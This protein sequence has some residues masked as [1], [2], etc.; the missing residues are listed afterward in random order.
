MITRGCLVRAKNRVSYRRPVVFLTLSEP[1]VGDR[2][3]VQG[4]T[5][6]DAL[7]RSGK[8]RTFYVEDLE[9]ISGV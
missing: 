2:F 1:Y 7:T 5:V 6:I 3:D 8:V 9:V 4:G